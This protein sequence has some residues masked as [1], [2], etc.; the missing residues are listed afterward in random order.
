MIVSPSILGTDFTRLGETVDL[1]NAS[2]AEMIHL[3]VMDGVFVPNISY[4]FP[5]ITS[6]AKHSTKILDAHL[7]IT[8]PDRY[9]NLC[10]EIGI[11]CLSVHYEVCTHL[12]RVLS[13]IR[14]KDMKAGVALNPHTP[15][16]ALEYSLEYADYVL[17]MGVNPGFGGQKFIE[18]TVH[19]TADLRKRIDSLGL[20]VQIEIDGGVSE[21][22]AQI[23]ADAGAD[24]LVTGNAVFSSENPTK[25]IDAIH[26]ISR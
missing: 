19:K 21:S 1:I 23:L 12:H 15:V 8:D 2:P 6:I 20:K 4:G 5:V 13:H 17:L 11:R 22:N 9:V 26:R 18:N 16:S 7:M 24:I 14:E 25:V 10:S 3:D